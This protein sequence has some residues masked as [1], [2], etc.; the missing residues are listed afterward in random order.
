MPEIGYELI[1]LLFAVAVVAGCID[2]IA[3]G[4]GLITVPALL[5]VGV[6]PVTAVATNKAQSTFGAASA[7]L[8][9]ARAGRIDWA[10]ARPMMVMA[11]LGSI[12]G[13]LAVTGLPQTA[14]RTF[15]PIVLVAMALYFWLSPALRDADARARIGA[16]LFMASAAP[17]IGFYDGAFGPGTGSFYMLA[18]VTLL[19]F[20]VLRA[21]A[22]TKA[23]NFASNLGGLGVFALTG[24]IN[25]FVGLTM[26]GGAFLGAQIGSRLALKHG[27]RLIRPLI[28]L[29]CLTVA[30]RLML[31]P[32]HPLGMWLRG[33]Q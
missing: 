24:H 4:G 1:A 20:G 6:D 2:A 27:V 16:G 32:A 10:S 12:A 13:A 28:V 21:T 29:V 17:L 31:D 33:T 22:H 14:L 11:G 3:G 18:F 25:W 8:A 26:A 5:L 19:G 7:T 30:A 23:L 9:F 15:M